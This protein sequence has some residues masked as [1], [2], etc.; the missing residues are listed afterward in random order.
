MVWLYGG[1]VVA[2]V[3]DVVGLLRER[4][5]IYCASGAGNVM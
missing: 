1:V 2:G 4:E 3:W 5:V